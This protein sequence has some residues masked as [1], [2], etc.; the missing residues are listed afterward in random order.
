MASGSLLP[1]IASWFDPLLQ[2]VTLG[3]PVL[4]VG[5][6]YATRASRGG[7]R[8]AMITA[9]MVA[10]IIAL[11]AAA[12]YVDPSYAANPAASAFGTLAL[13]GPSLVIG[14]IVFRL[15]GQWRWNPVMQ[16]MAAA[17]CAYFIMGLCLPL[18]FYVAIML[19]GDTL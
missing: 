13:V 2:I 3:A 18:V 7:K 1:G 16:G 9:S 19:G 12:W 17:A 5:L 4:L 8:A 15:A 11:G 14:T 6:L 10:V